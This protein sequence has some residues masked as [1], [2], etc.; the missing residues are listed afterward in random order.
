MDKKLLL[1]ITFLSISF[2]GLSQTADTVSVVTAVSAADTTMLNNQDTVP[3]SE[4]PEILYTFVH[5]K[6][7]IQHIKVTGA[8]NYEDFV[9]IGFSGLSVG[10]EISVPGEEITEAVNRFWRQ[11]LFSDIK[12]LA[13]RMVDDKVW[14]E[15]R[16]KPRPRISEITYNGVKKGERTDLD[17]KLNLRKGQQ[18]TPHIVDRAKILIKK[19]FDDKGFKNVDIDVVEKPDPVKEGEVIV[20][21]NIDK[22]EKTK[23]QKIYFDGNEMLTDFQLRKA[24]KKTNERFNMIDRFRNSW[25]ELFSTKKFTTAEYENDKNNLIDRYNEFGYRDAVI[26]ADSIAPQ[27]KKR[28]NIFLT[29][30]EGQKYYLKDIRFVGNTKY[31]SDYLE[32]LLNM[33][34]GD[35]YNQKKLMD[36]MYSD[37]DAVMN[38][39]S[40]NGY[41]FANADPVEVDVQNDSIALE[42]RIIEGPQ[43]TIN[44]VII[45]GNDRLYEDIVRREL[46]TK[47]G[48]LFSREALMRSLRELAQMGHFDPENMKPDFNTNPDNGTVDLIYNLTSKANDQIEFSLGWGQTG[49]IG[50]LGLKF[51][52]FSMKNLLNTKTYKGIIPQGEGQTLNISGQTNAQYY[53]AYSVSFLDPWFGGKKP[54][55]LSLSA[56]FSRY[57]GINNRYYNQLQSQY[58]SNYYNNYY[59]S[60]YGNSYYGNSYYGNDYGNSYESAYD[61]S[62]YMQILGFSVGY[63]KRLNWPDDYFQAMAT[64][65]YQMYMLNNWT[66][67]S[68]QLGLPDNG[69]YHDINLELT[70]QR[71]SVD[72]PLYTRLGSQFILTGASTLPYSLF[73]GK[74]YKNMTSDV[75]RYKLVEY[76]KVKF[77]SKVFIP[78]IL[79]TQYGG[80]LRT[81]VLMSRVEVGWIG[82][83]SRYKKSPF[84]TFYVGGD[85]MTGGYS[86]YQETVALRGYDNG[87]IA[88]NNYSMP[89]ARAYS[90]MSLELRYP[91]ILEPSSTIYALIFGEAG[92]AWNSIADFKPFNLKRSAGVGVRIFLP[93]IGLMG[94]DWAYGFDKPYGSANR[95]G[96]NFH[97][98]L[99]QEF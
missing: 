12:I 37:E 71:N 6:Y 85:G 98:I 18:I 14:L 16:V 90:R 61:K 38:V 77:K 70:F 24:M 7:K 41:M 78:L 92:D 39:Y 3:E 72:N 17:T 30:E 42:V 22:N 69:N 81:P 73:D 36:R 91:L 53:Q 28:I 87:E 64:L 25:L 94:I 84:G 60:Y 80:P 43:A 19:Y 21:V 35:V 20:S 54:N 8:T 59:N 48:D 75:E 47:P 2:G 82:D 76:Y 46:R 50:K 23:I 45:N 31:S 34:S 33:K 83:Y 9:L 55:S 40:N 93:M 63:G 4:I 49:V 89:N 68:Y 79:P 56:Y 29:I 10:D 96:G 88:G 65:N 51:T 95:G 57:T 26:V 32:D 97:F 52:N 66:S 27:D 15:I 11:G 5:K 13:T 44:K 86:Y 99:G 1:F 62:K 67:A 74:D 58:L